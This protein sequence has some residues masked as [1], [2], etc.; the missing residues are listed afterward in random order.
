MSSILFVVVKGVTLLRDPIKFVLQNSLHTPVSEPRF[1][2]FAK[3]CCRLLSN[4]LTASRV[5]KDDN[6][7]RLYDN[8]CALCKFRPDTQFTLFDFQ[9]SCV[10]QDNFLFAAKLMWRVHFMAMSISDSNAVCK[11]MQTL[12][13]FRWPWIVIY[14]SICPV[15]EQ[16]SPSSGNQTPFLSVSPLIGF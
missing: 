10:L 7:P 16:L 6:K 2:Y 1:C 9:L 11:P 3:Q 4:H 5:E 12:L 13:K 14:L 8:V 15:F